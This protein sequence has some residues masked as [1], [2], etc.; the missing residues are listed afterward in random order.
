[1]LTSTW[2]IESLILKSCKYSRKNNVETSGI[3]KEVP[4]EDLENHV[5]EICKNSNNMINPTDIEGCHR[6]PLGRNSTTDNKRV[7]VKFVNR[8]H[9][10]LM[11]RSKTSII[12]K[13]KVNYSFVISLLPLYLGKMQRSAKEKQSSQVF[14]LGVVVT[15]RVT[16][17]DPHMNILHERT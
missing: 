6:L 11:L 12:S 1:M 9:S 2:R 14:C 4:D 13:S 8:K 5:I 17:N 16:E 10:E 3:S 15:I 7:I